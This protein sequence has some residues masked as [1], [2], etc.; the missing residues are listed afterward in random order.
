MSDF[1][2]FCVAFVVTNTIILVCEWCGFHG[3][4]TGYEGVVARF[5]L[6]CTVGISAVVIR[7][8]R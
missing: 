8:A 6:D 3:R 1:R 7:S 2:L 5:V 4:Y